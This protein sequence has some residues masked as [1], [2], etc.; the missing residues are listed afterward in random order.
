MYI[1]QSKFYEDDIIL[2]DKEDAL[3]SSE[4]KEVIL[5]GK[6]KKGVPSFSLVVFLKGPSRAQPGPSYPSYFQF[7]YFLACLYITLGVIMLYLVQASPAGLG[8]GHEG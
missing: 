2:L 1:V 6:L 7:I 8:P 4:W 5:M 3:I